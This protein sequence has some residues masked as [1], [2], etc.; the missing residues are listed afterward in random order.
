M[1]TD[2]LVALLI[3]V[4][5]VSLSFGLK[6]Y[7]NSRDKDTV[8]GLLEGLDDT[9]ALTIFVGS[10]LKQLELKN[11]KNIDKIVD[12]II[13]SLTYVQEITSVQTNKEKIDLAY[14]QVIK[15]CKES[16]IELNEEMQDT[17]KTA[18]VLTFNLMTKLENK[19][20]I[21]D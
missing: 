19:K 1:N 10:I 16:S 12:I 13:D 7:C 8:E 2:V 9:K 14:G 20:K 17:L 6:M 3:V 18:V 5:V 11:K 21:E 15:L 4:A